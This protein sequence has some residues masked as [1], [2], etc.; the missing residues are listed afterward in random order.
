MTTINLSEV[1]GTGYK[2]FWRDK[3]HRYVVVKG[4]RASKKSKTAALWIIYHMM[5]YPL[6]N[7]LVIR[8]VFNTL[9]DSCWT[10][11]KW[12]AKRLHV[13]KLWKFSKSPLQAEYLPTGQKI[14]FR[15]LDNPMSITSIAVEHGVL[16]F[17][18]LNFLTKK[19]HLNS[20]KLLTSNVEDNHERSLILFNKM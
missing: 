4:S 13:E 7:T 3:T 18:W 11:L 17:V 14:L 12:A 19:N 5:K 16:N 1:I 20:W 9:K 6:S 15:G 2:Q 10:D 8:R